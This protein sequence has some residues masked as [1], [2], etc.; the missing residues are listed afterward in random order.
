[1]VF[2]I[3]RDS[4]CSEC[5]RELLHGSLLCLKNGEALCLDCADLDHLEYLP[6]GDAALTRRTRKHSGLSAVVLEFSRSHKRY[7]RRGILAEPEAIEKAEAECVADADL[8]AA[9]KA[10]QSVIRAELDQQYVQ[11]FA[12]TVRRR[13]PGCPAGIENKTAEHACRKY[14]GRVGRSAM[15]KRLDPEAVFLAVQAFVRHRFTDY[16]DLL[17]AGRDRSDAR[18]EVEGKVSEVL[19]G[20]RESQPVND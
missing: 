14:S 6:R 11:A 17:M 3:R 9:R 8:R 15:A 1:V 7:E 10:R 4:E 2:R 16:D 18:S 5:N 12:A 19:A 13:F 20:W